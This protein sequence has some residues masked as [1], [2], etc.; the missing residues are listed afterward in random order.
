MG[1]EHLLIGFFAIIM[2][3][4]T[5]KYHISCQKCVPCYFLVTRQSNSVSPHKM[6]SVQR[7]HMF[8]FAGKPMQPYSVR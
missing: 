8:F 1:I 5:Y 3:K 2:I 7:L 6:F 4:M